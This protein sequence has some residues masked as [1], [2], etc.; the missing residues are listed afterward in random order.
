MLADD[1]DTIPDLGGCDVCAAPH[2]SACTCSPV[3]TTT[4]E[5]ELG[6]MLRAGRLSDAELGEL[7]R[8]IA[9]GEPT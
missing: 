9:E 2:W 5:R 7:E 1:L 4:R 6:R 8:L 3:P